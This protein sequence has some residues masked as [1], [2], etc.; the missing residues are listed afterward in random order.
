MPASLRPLSREDRDDLSMLIKSAYLKGGCYELAIAL[1]RGLGWQMVGLMRGEEIYHVAL[2]HPTNAKNM[3]DARGFFHEKD[4]GAPFGLPRPYVTKDV[5]EK[6]LRA[7]REIREHA[8]E[9]AAKQAGA[10]W[11]DLPWKNGLHMRVLAFAQELEALSRKHKIWIFTNIQETHPPMLSVDFG[12]ESG[13]EVGA[14]LGGLT[15]AI[16]R[17]VK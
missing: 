2:R 14:M 4:F 13:Y 15:Y 17:K 6:D 1:S 9:S 16:R 12:E 3:F 7:V 10:R 11:P 8:V 5:T